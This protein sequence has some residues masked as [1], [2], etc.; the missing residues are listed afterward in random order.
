MKFEPFFSR[1][2]RSQSGITLIEML[3]VTAVLMTLTALAQPLSE[4]FV[5]R[6][7]E[8]ALKHR[9]K[10]IRTAIDMF[11]ADWDRDA[12]ELIGTL[13][14]NNKLVC[15]EMSSENGYPR[16]L[17]DLVHSDNAADAQGLSK[18][19]LRKLPIDP[20]TGNANWG[21]RCY[22]D[23]QDTETWCGDDVFD[24]YSKSEAV[25]M[26]QTEYRMW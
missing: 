21:L 10:K 20:M 3:V 2:R 9:L 23:P 1:F 15:S 16:Q 4:T 24:V 18:P 19:Y 5:H 14:Q 7:K 26:N 25:A 17:E 12:E 8:V 11:K 22:A 13:C 6:A